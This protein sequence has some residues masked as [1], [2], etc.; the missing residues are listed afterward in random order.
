MEERTAAKGK[1]QKYF[2]SCIKQ[3]DSRVTVNWKGED[4]GRIA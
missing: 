1:G 2:S 3:P 4:G